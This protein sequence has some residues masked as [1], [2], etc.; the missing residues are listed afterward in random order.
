G[1]ATAHSE[2][3]KSF[4]P[5]FS[6]KVFH[7]DSNEII[8]RLGMTSAV[9]IATF[10]SGAVPLS[11]MKRGK[12]TKSPFADAFPICLNKQRPTA[13]KPS[14]P[15]P[16]SNPAPAQTPHPHPADAP[17]PAVQGTRNRSAE[18]HHAVPES[19]KTPAYRR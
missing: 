4:I 9:A 11:S 7:S 16:P 14:A 5:H 8:R 2:V 3:W 17:P 18:P 13:Y 6:M 1:F 19:T 15:T 12:H 10:C